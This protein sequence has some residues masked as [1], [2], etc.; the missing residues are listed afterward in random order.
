M[1]QTDSVTLALEPR[2]TQKN[3]PHLAATLAGHRY[4]PVNLDASAVIHIGAPGFEVLLSAARGW[5]AKS[6]A[7]TLTDPSAAFMDGLVRI[8]LSAEDFGLNEG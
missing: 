3:A 8:G 6:V 7:F 5:M 1:S 2:I 4:R